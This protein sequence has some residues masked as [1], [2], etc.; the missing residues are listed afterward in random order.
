MRCASRGADSGNHCGADFAGQAG[1]VEMSKKQSAQTARLH[2][3]GEIGIVDL[4]SDAV[5]PLLRDRFK[6]LVIAANGG[7]CG[8][9][10]CGA[11]QREGRSS[12]PDGRPARIKHSRAEVGYGMFDHS[13]VESIALL[14]SALVSSRARH[15]RLRRVHSGACGRP[16]QA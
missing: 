11:R 16:R 9:F 13:R 6:L 5:S 12:V 2:F 10:A 14:Q 15:R 8:F 4:A 3:A 7:L 1:L